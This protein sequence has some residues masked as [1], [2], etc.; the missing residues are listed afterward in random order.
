LEDL[1][2]HIR[3]EKKRM[4]DIDLELKN[5]EHDLSGVKKERNAAEKRIEELEQ[6]HEWIKQDSHDF[7]KPGTIYD[8]SK[9]NPVDLQT[10]YNGLKE[11]GKKKKINH[12]AVSMLER[13]VF[14]GMCLLLSF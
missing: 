10:R 3:K 4:A 13:F 11:S 1:E 12:K 2:E 6:M 14:C 7:G 9:T 5:L 8:F